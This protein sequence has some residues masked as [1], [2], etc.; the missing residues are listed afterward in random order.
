MIGASDECSCR[1]CEGGTTS[2]TWFHAIVPELVC[3]RLLLKFVGKRARR[4][5]ASSTVCLTKRRTLKLFYRGGTLLGLFLMFLSCC[6]LVVSSSYVFYSMVTGFYSSAPLETTIQRTATVPSVIFTPIVPGVNLPLSDIPLL[7]FILSISLAFHEIGH[8][9]SAYVHNVRTTEAGLFLVGIFPAAYCSIDNGGMKYLNFWKRLD[10]Y[11]GGVINNLAA[12]LFAVFC[13]YLLNSFVF[14]F[15]FKPGLTVM[16]IHEETQPLLLHESFDVGDQ[17]MAVNAV[18]VTDKSGWYKEIMLCLGQSQNSSL[19]IRDCTFTVRRG[20]REATFGA[21]TTEQV[22]SFYNSLHLA[23]YQFTTLS[24]S[25]NFRGYLKFLYIPSVVQYICMFMVMINFS[26]AMINIF[27]VYY[28]DGMHIVPVILLILAPS[29]Q[30]NKISL[31][32]HTH[33]ILRIG[34]GLFVLNVVFAWA[35]LLV[36]VK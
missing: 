14:N 8:A 33:T 1:C 21:K 18:K 30:S 2:C 26:L 5:T 10:I 11:F 9:V 28:F 7:M 32:R 22:A 35:S 12:A 29:Y 17:I 3:N 15:F 16:S 20:A 4:E 19:L 34:F 27:P 25:L 23:D 36:D 13:L 31:K 24:D 6:V